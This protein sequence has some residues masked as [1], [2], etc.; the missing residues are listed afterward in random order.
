[1]LSP[2]TQFVFHD[3]AALDATDRMFYAHANAIDASVFFLFFCGQVAATRF[4]L[5]L[6]DHN[7]INLEA[8][9][10]HILIQYASCWKLIQFTVSSSFVMTCSFPRRSQAPHANSVVNN[11]DI[12]DRMM[13]LLSTI[14]P[15]LLVGITWPIYWPLCS[16]MEKKGVVCLEQS[17]RVSPVSLASVIFSSC[18]GL[19][20]A[21]PIR[22]FR[23][24]RSPYCFNAR[25]STECNR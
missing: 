12:L 7:A 11:H 14:V 22:M 4:L 10:S 16:I 17:T 25:L 3:A 13:S 9:K 6:D 24:G 20:S 1:M 23:F 15:F 18:S 5:W 2:Q 21:N 8:L 19:I